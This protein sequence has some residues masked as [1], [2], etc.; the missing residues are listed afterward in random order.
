[1]RLNHAEILFA[2]GALEKATKAVQEIRK[3]ENISSLLNSRAQAL[4][5]KIRR[6]GDRSQ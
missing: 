4:A 3:A 6:A 2:K 5:A 1:V